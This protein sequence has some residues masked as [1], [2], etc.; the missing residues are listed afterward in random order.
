MKRI[1]YKLARQLCIKI[2]KFHNIQYRFDNRTYC[3]YG[4]FTYSKNMATIGTKIQK[5]FNAYDIIHTAMHE[6]IHA[7]CHR[8]CVYKSYH[9]PRFDFNKNTIYGL[10][11][12]IW[13]L[14]DYIRTAL[15]AERYVEKLACRWFS[16]LFGCMPKNIAYYKLP[17]YVYSHQLLYKIK[18]LRIY[19]RCLLIKKTNKKKWKKLKNIPFIKDIMNK[20]NER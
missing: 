5:K 13:S 19:Y 15:R 18:K 20:Y 17:N 7:L 14:D 4:C 10:K 9:G 1:T 11:K 12:Y 6:T 3:G 16:S 8:K 2:F